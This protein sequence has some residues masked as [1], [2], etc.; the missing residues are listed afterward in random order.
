MTITNHNSPADLLR[1]VVH[2]V[3]PIDIIATGNRLIDVHVDFD[4]NPSN[5]LA[6]DGS[7][8]VQCLSCHGVHYADSN[9]LTVDAP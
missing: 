8:N 3:D 2:H 4:G 1:H 6:F 5:D 9:T 7:G